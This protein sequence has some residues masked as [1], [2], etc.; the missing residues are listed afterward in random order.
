MTPRR[1]PEPHARSPTAIKALLLTGACIALLAFKLR[2]HIAAHTDGQQPERCKHWGAA[3]RLGGG[4]IGTL[5][6]GTST[7]PCC[8]NGSLGTGCPE[9]SQHLLQTLGCLA[10]RHMLLRPQPGCAALPPLLPRLP[11][12]LPPQ[13]PCGL[14]PK[15]L[16]TGSWVQAAPDALGAPPLSFQPAAPCRQQRALGSAEVPGCL[17]AAGFDRVVVSGDSTA[18]Q[19]Y[20]RLIG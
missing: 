11:P 1:G 19:L 2:R 20:T 15:A 18:R 6:P 13:L 12:P 4:C 5:Q 8:T 3:S 7:F 10:P 9:C 17:W 16:I 14:T